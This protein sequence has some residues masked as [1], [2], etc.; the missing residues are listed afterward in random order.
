MASIQKRKNRDG[1]TSYVARVRVK[2]FRPVAKSFDTKRAAEEWSSRLEKELHDK[3]RSGLRKDLTKLTI[4]DLVDHFRKDPENQGL[5]YYSSLELLLAWWVND[6]GGER[7]L[8]VNVLMLREAR[9]RLRRGRGPATV[10]RYLSA[11]RSAWNWGRAAGIVPQDRHWPTRLMLTEDNERQRYLSATELVA[12][13]DAARAHGAMM[14]AAVVLS[15]GCGLRQGEL[16]RVQWADLDLKKQR[17]RILRTKTDEPRGVYVP[18][19]ACDALKALRKED[20][21][22][23]GPVFLTETGEPLDKGRLR[24]R[25][26]EVRQAA[27]L[28]DFRWHDLR[29]SCASFLAQQGA[30][31]LEIGSVLGHRSAAVT[32]RYSHLIEGAPVTGH[33]ELDEMLRGRP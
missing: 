17:L 3:K 29:H 31:L 27:G 5:R 14:Y 33:T 9:D 24:H 23:V 25:W 6:Y 16:F 19:A 32:R 8:E 20:V 7:L 4:S 13:L 11:L 22:S 15:I 28:A 26:I 1:S 18:A 21:V 30:T 2:Q 12:L 10:N